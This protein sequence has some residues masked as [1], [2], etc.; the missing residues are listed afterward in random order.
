[1]TP[2]KK[3][4]KLPLEQVP[5]AVKDNIESGQICDANYKK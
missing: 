2:G 5:S 4:E 3:E 1:L